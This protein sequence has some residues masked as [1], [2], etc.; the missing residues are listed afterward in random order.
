MPPQNE[1]TTVGLTKAEFHRRYWFSSYQLVTV[2][3]PRAEDFFFMVEMRHYTVPAGGQESYPGPIAN[4]YLDQMT[5]IITQDEEKMELLSD[6]MFKANYYN[7]LIVEVKNL[8]PESQKVTWQDEMRKKAMEMPPWMQNQPPGMSEQSTNPQSSTVPPWEQQPP[9]AT[10]AAPQVSPQTALVQPP[11]Q[12]DEERSFEYKGHTFKMVTKGEYTEYLRD[13]H[14]ISA[15]VYNK[16]A[17]M[18]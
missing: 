4:M 14:P 9:T 13:S 6:F 5:K 12:T 11:P 17:S 1:L 3:N 10:P 8:A 7:K 18:L 16:A 2:I 15:E